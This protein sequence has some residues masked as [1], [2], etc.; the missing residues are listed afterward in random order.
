MRL[1]PWRRLRRSRAAGRSTAG[2]ALATAAVLSCLIGGITAVA[3]GEP[4]WTTYH[5]DAG[6]SGYDPD[7]A[8]PLPPSLAWQ[9]VDLG[10]PIWGQPLVLGSRVYVATVANGLYALDAAT[11]AVIWSR[12]AGPPVPSSQLPCGDVSPT[13]GIV[14]TP[15]IDPAAA[16]IFAVADVWNQAT[17][18]AQHV[19]VG[20][21]L[22]SGVEVLRTPVDP[23]N[24]EP[25]DYLQ[26]TALNLD[27]GNVIFG[28]GGNDGDCGTYRGT[29]VSAPE[30]GGAPAFWQ[31]PIAVKTQS[32]GAVWGTSG[33]IVDSQGRIFA[34]TGNPNPGG[35]KATVYDESDSLVALGPALNPIG[36]FKPPS[37]EQDSNSDT[38]L[39]SAG[40]ELLPG[41]LI[42]QA[43]KNGTGYLLDETM[44]KGTPAVFSQQVCGGAGSFGGDAYYAGVIY[45]ACSNG[46]QALAYN[47]AARSFAP[48]WKGPGDAAGPPI[49]SAGLVWVV[50]T[51]GSRPGTKLYGLDPATGAPRYT[52]TLPSAAVDHFASPSA[53]GGRLFV[54]TGTTVTA[55]Q[56]AVPPPGSGSAIVPPPLPPQAAPTRQ[57]SVAA[58]LASTSLTVNSSGRLTVK[59]RCPAGVTVCKGT[60]TL[61]TLKAVLAEAGPLAVARGGRARAA[62]LTLATGTFRVPG[63]HV[64]AITLH[65]RSRAMRLLRRTHVLRARAV[66]VIRDGA[67]TLRSSRATVTLHL[68]RGR[69]R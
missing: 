35:E 4:A 17:G 29:V 58:T 42:F 10:G 47:Q 12:T 22:T 30:S 65:L 48:T 59:V 5:H 41:G 46:T 18:K 51:H 55:Y 53:A 69:R 23:A 11:G 1:G 33:P 66:L 16:E 28:F 14:G 57:P 7:G 62:I 32:G 25:K 60:I 52:E 50:A 3:R 19:L 37:W 31:V 13:V 54:A 20:Y 21:G 39:G 64:K 15:V 49:V 43:G 44:G 9:S 2:T 56:I 61:R 27:G 63:G 34:S 40:P 24:A 26:R 45:V 67:G 68:A 8:S 38:D 36:Y 6:R